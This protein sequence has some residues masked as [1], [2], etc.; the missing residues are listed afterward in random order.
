[1]KKSAPTEHRGNRP[2]AHL[3]GLDAGKF[4]RE[5]W[6]K[7]PLLIRQAF[8]NFTDPLDKKSVLALAAREDA[9]SRLIANAQGKWQ[10][11]HGPLSR[12][13]FTSAK[14]ALWTVLVQDTQ[15]FSRAAHDVLA[16]FNFIPSA[17]IEDLMVSYA[18]PGAGVGAHFDSYDVFLLQGMG[19]RRWRISAQEDLRLKAGLPLKVLS[20]F[21]HDQEYILE[22]GDMLYLP[23]GYAHEGVAETESLTWSIGFLAPSRQDLAMALL[24][25][26]RDEIVV[27]GVYRDPDLLPT[28]HPGEI[29]VP[30]LASLTRMLTDVQE[31]TR[32]ADHI[33]RC[34]GRLLTDPKPH[35]FFDS[36]E[37]ALDLAAFRRAALINGVELDLKSRFLYHQEMFFLNGAEFDA[38][39]FDAMYLRQLA[40]TRKLLPVILA[41][42]SDKSLF[43]A[44]FR[45]YSEGFLH[46]A[47]PA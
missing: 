46:I 35:V 22:S 39:P 20:H 43:V 10:L 31:A 29:G 13:D 34:L 1:M 38:T 32:N 16:A 7:K 42:V 14:N 40:D 41:H 26:L 19:R 33:R 37:P 12:R 6:Q 3:G 25:Y 47:P 28:T 8:P 23:P 11:T 27:D 24:D 45:A 44:L 2:I 21:K 18:V 17:R 5:Y 9:E 4:L 15:H 30:M 36:P